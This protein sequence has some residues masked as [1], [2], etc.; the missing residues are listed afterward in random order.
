LARPGSA[1]PDLARLG[2]AWLGLAWGGPLSG[3]P[4]SHHGRDSRSQPGDLAIC[5]AFVDYALGRCVANRTLSQ[6][7]ISPSQLDQEVLVGID[8]IRREEPLGALHNLYMPGLNILLSPGFAQ[9][10]Q[11]LLYILLVEGLTRHERIEGIDSVPHALDTGTHRRLVMHVTETP[12]F[13]LSRSLCCLLGVSQRCY[14]LQYPRIE[15][16]KR[17]GTV[18]RIHPYSWFRP[19]IRPHMP[20]ALLF[21]ATHAMKKMPESTYGLASA[22][23]GRYRSTKQMEDRGLAPAIEGVN[24][25]SSIFHITDC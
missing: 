4:F 12:V 25:N 18:F 21:N 24:P 15:L 20:T 7:E 6:I 5:C 3:F 10:A 11:M 19:T 1:W 9:G 2:S 17:D 8:V 16:R 23:H 14:S 13:G 22:P